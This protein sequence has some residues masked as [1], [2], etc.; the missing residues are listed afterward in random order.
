MARYHE[1][2]RRSAV[3]GLG[4]GGELWGDV[5]AHPAAARLEA[6]P[7]AHL[8]RFDDRGITFRITRPLLLDVIHAAGG[9]EYTVEKLLAALEVVQQW[10]DER[11]VPGEP[12][13]YDV[14]PELWDVSFEV[15]N[16]V[17]WARTLNK[18]LQDDSREEVRTKIGLLPALADG[19]L[20]D[21]VKRFREQLDSWTKA[22]SWLAGYALH[23][24]RLHGGGPV[25]HRGPDGRVRFLLP[26]PPKRKNRIWSSEE[27]TYRQNRD[28]E[29]VAVDLLD[30]VERFMDGLLT[31]FEQRVPQRPQR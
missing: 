26:D 21:Q 28:A 15:S 7:R 19:D 12:S 8:E 6:I 4:F 16:L 29:T 13:E 3:V 30:R 11:S 22:E 2:V 10:T 14:V 17:V 31:T 23:I 18:R 5:S 9:V 25:L 1:W 27:F 20:K 24:G